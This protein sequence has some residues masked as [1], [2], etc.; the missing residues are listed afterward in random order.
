M[1]R[2]VVSGINPPQAFFSQKGQQRWVKSPRVKSSSQHLSE[3]MV[4]SRMTP[5][6]Y[7]TILS[8]KDHW[9]GRCLGKNC[10]F[11][12]LIN[13]HSWMQA[14]LPLGWKREEERLLSKPC[15]DPRF[16]K[17]TPF[18]SSPS[19]TSQGYDSSICEC[20]CFLGQKQV[21]KCYASRI[22][23]PLFH[24][25]TYCNTEKIFPVPLKCSVLILPPPPTWPLSC[26]MES[27]AF[28]SRKGWK[29]QYQTDLLSSLG[30]VFLKIDG[31]I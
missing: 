20:K 19:L 9:L 22:T 14:V 24:Q 12:R 7:F 18:L 17:P 6:I 27:L 3:G 4:G 10:P 28:W 2:W 8:T 23:C 15:S 5:W 13:K 16:D 1:E 26:P 31:V 30:S 21:R 29:D 25:C 11:Q